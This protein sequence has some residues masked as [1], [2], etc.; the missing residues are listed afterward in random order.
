MVE[1]NGKIP[2]FGKRLLREFVTDYNRFA[3]LYRRNLFTVRCDRQWA[4]GERNERY[5]ATVRTCPG[6]AGNA[7][8]GTT[9]ARRAPNLQ[10]PGFEIVA[11]RF[12]ANDNCSYPRADADVGE[13][14]DN[15]PGPEESGRDS[16]T[17]DWKSANDN[18]SRIAGTA[19]HQVMVRPN[20][21]NEMGSSLRYRNATAATDVGDKNGTDGRREQHVY[22]EK[23]A[24]VTAAATRQTDDD[25]E[26]GKPPA[27]GV[28][29]E[30]FDRTV[31]DGLSAVTI[32]V[33]AD[34]PDYGRRAVT[35]AVAADVSGNDLDGHA[36]SEKTEPRDG[37]RR[38]PSTA[39]ATDP[40]TTAVPERPSDVTVPRQRRRKIQS[41]TLPSPPRPLVKDIRTMDDGGGG[42]N[43]FGR[44]RNVS[45]TVSRAVSRTISAPG[46]KSNWLIY[47]LCFN[48]IFVI[49]VRIGKCE[50]GKG[51]Q[52]DGALLLICFIFLRTFSTLLYWNMGGRWMYLNY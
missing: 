26:T 41:S 25:G 35:I 51:G 34:E 2:E 23:F 7:G 48:N 14:N 43:N 52:R 42:Q 44:K 17:R 31:V 21:G 12:G 18:R 20:L 33:A 29:R 28:G 3:F 15:R 22:L 11:D 4:A 36:P 39:L 30:D 13:K 1:Q 37:R 32:A 10:Y 45:A 9:L 24:A 16:H 8:E 38:W 47:G 5:P 46:N 50:R 49:H 27:N 40:T 6:N 19:D